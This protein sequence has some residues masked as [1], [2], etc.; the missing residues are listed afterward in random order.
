ML[1]EAKRGRGRGVRGKE[2]KEGKEG[3]KGVN[4]MMGGMENGNGDG[5]G[6]VEGKEN[7]NGMNG[8]GDGANA[9]NAHTTLNG[10]LGAMHKRR[11]RSSP[12]A[13]AGSYTDDD[14]DEEDGEGNTDVEGSS[15]WRAKK[16][17]TDVG[18]PESVVSEGVK[19]V[20][21]VLEGMVDVVD[22]GAGGEGERERRQGG[23]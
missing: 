10:H 18:V 4:G 22:D 11:R 7:G 8:D 21:E 13:D 20:R 15:G 3:K 16:R 6:K 19:V 2:G 14:D 5:D 12:N 17:K 9:V 1:G 23:E